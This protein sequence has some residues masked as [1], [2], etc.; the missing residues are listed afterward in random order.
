MCTVLLAV[1]GPFQAL[2]QTLLLMQHLQRAAMG[3]QEG[4]DPS[5]GCC[6]QDAQG[7]T[8]NTSHLVFLLGKLLQMEIFPFPFCFLLTFYLPLP[9]VLK[10]YV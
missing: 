1:P 7:S 2:S 5:L 4:A 3:A 6:S 9:R 10:P 8:S